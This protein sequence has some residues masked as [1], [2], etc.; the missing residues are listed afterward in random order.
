M[1]AWMTESAC[2]AWQVASQRV[3][4]LEQALRDWDAKVGGVRDGWG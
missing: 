3:A 1:C 2:G 4:E